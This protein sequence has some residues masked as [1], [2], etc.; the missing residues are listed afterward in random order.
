M[1]R[2]IFIGTSGW[3]YKHWNQTFYSNI[4]KSDQLAF[5]AKEFIT[6]EI[7][8]TFYRIPE[9]KAYINWYNRT[10][11]DFK[12]SIK[13]NRFVTHL[14]RLIIDEETK[15]ALS[16]FLNDAQGLREK[17]AVILIQLQ[18]KQFIDYSR[19]STFL[20]E[21][22]NIVDKLQFKPLTTIE[23]RN[24]TWLT[25][26]VYELL[27][28]Y[29]IALVFP[30]TPDLRRLIFTSDFAFIRMHG[31]YSFSEEELSRLKEEIDHYP[32]G[33]R[34]VFVYFNNDI[35]T[36]AVINAKFLKSIT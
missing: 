25:N 6:V 31:G 16:S 9:P 10:P 24:T 2:D 29:K 22:T 35:N 26:E 5:Y 17:L 8:Y 3:M 18:P 33:I 20:E 21:Y 34:K 32:S 30:S 27:E 4:G 11:K 12:F 23:F 7:N 15:A 14:K 28:N 13:L 1:K 19:L 36:Y